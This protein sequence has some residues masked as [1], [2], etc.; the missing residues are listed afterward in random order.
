MK[1]QLSNY[2]KNVSGK[3]FLKWPDMLKTASHGNGWRGGPCL[4]EIELTVTDAD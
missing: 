3:P 4:L 2:L 1:A